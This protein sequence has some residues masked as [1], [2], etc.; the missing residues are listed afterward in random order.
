[1]DR[2]RGD[3]EAQASA[4]ITADTLSTGTQTAISLAA[5]GNADGA[6]ALLF[7]IAVTVAPTGTAYLEVW[8]AALQQDGVGDCEPK[9]VARVSLPITATG[10]YTCT[11]ESADIPLSGKYYIKAVGDGLTASLSVDSK[12][13]SAT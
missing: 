11:F 10:N 2:F 4:A 7:E 5:S 1:M 8:C 6:F 12:Y 13:E 3:V 9:K